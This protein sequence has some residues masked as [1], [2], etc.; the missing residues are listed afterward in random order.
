MKNIIWA[1]C[2]ALSLLCAA[3]SPVTAQNAGAGSP[4]KAAIETLNLVSRKAML[5]QRIAQ[6]VCF[7]SH[8]V[9]PLNTKQQAQQAQW[10]FDM[11]L[12]RMRGEGVATLDEFTRIDALWAPFNAAV[13]GWMGWSGDVAQHVNSIYQSNQPLADQAEQ[14]ADMLRAQYLDDGAL[15]EGAAQQLAL[16][17]RLR[18]LTQKISKEYCFVAYNYEKAANA[19]ALEESMRQFDQLSAALISGSPELNVTPVDAEAASRLTQA[20][21]EYSR[22]TPI[23]KSAVSGGALPTDYNLLVMNQTSRMLVELNEASL[24]FEKTGN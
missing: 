4:Q 11:E 24:S 13:S 15:P 16:K 12:G 10:L 18:V 21:N 1:A 17:D 14:L 22:I 20:R 9:D 23:L 5:S 6:A 19:P 3:P 2:G 7:A 8:G